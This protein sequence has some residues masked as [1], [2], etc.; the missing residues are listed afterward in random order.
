MDSHSIVKIKSDE[1]RLRWIDTSS[2]HQLMFCQRYFLAKIIAQC[3]IGF[4][5]LFKVILL[6]AGFSV[7]G[8]WQTINE[9][10]FIVN[11]LFTNVRMGSIMNCT[12]EVQISITI[13][14][15]LARQR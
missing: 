3:F 8:M 1:A 11:A 4:T 2:S 15:T 7:T 5:V 10:W 9:Q 14:Y 13:Y 6:T 12:V